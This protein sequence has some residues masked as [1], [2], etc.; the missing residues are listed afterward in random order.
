MPTNPPSIPPRSN[1]RIFTALVLALMTFNCVV[2][3]LF[4]APALAGEAKPADEKK[5]NGDATK[6]GKDI[7]KKVDEI[8]E[9]AK[10]VAGP[11]GQPECVWVGRRIVGLL[12]RD[13]LETANRHRELYEK[14]GCPFPY[15]Q[16]AFR[17]VVRNGD[18][19]PKAPE[20]LSLRIH[21]CWINPALVPVPPSVAADA[22][23][24]APAPVQ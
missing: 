21:A 4:T 22:A 11:A 17:C 10:L 7:A 12:W 23:Q 19:D 1:V 24:P 9:A 6:D 14:F 8:A 20:A 13:D 5:P 18:L 16:D 15:I 2:P 3:S